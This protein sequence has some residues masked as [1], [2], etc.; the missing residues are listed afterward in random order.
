VRRKNHYTILGITRGETPEGVRA[1]YLRLV[2]ALHPDH[3]GASSARAFREV[4]KA[5]DVLSD[6]AKRQR[7]DDQLEPKRPARTWYSEPLIR[8]HGVEPLVR[9]E[10]LSEPSRASRSTPPAD[11]FARFLFGPTP[12]GTNPE[13][14]PSEIDVD[15]TLSAA[16]AARGGDVVLLIP[17]RELCPLC[18]GTGLDWARPCSACRRSGI[19]VS[20]QP[21]RLRLPPRVRNGTVVHLRLDHVGGM[22]VRVHL[23]VDTKLRAPPPW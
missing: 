14:Y 8:D 13:S 5:Y 1:A 19:V 7:Y 6:P 23:V 21:V 10:P 17:V 4:Q 22:V 20:E 18:G 3:A 2:K 16:R 12:I 9:E 11:V 15:V